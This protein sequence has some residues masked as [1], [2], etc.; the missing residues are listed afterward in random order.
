MTAQYVLDALGPTHSFETRIVGSAPMIGGRIRIDGDLILVG[1]SDPMLDTDDLAAM[2]ASL[3]ARGLREVTGRLL[4][5]AGHLPVL[6][7]IDADQPEQL[8][9]N[10]AIS[11]LTLNF[12][13]VYFEWERTGG[14]YDLSM[15]ACGVS[16]QPEIPVTTMSVEDRGEPVF[17]YQMQGDIEQW[18]VARSALGASGAR[19]L[20]VRS[21]LLYAGHALRALAGEAGLSLA[22]P[23]I[24]AT[25]PHGTILVTHQSIPLRPIMRSMLYYSTNLIAETTG[26]AASY[27]RGGSP[28]SLAASAGMM[29]DWMVARLGARRPRFVDHSGLG[30]GT[31]VRATDLVTALVRIG[32][33]SML[34]SLMR[35]FPV[36]QNAGAIEVVAKTGTLHFVSGLAGFARVGQRDLAFAILASDLDRRSAIPKAE[37]ERPRGAKGWS[38]RARYQDRQLLA[39]WARRFG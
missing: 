12:N 24:A 25:R 13:R 3:V 5:Y 7:R 1:G 15:D 11:G 14:G 38:S 2:A 4:V 21:P 36:S 9:Y 10:P 17:D 39:E 32:P 20:P 22:N 27:A 33:D 6:P 8:A 31:R 29:N 23:Q 16:H 26:L 18:S 35:K 37:L 19:W 30:D 28:Q 34:A